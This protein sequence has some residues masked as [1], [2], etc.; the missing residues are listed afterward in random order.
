M[1]L[2]TRAASSRALCGLSLVWVVAWTAPG[3]VALAGD[4]VLQ[5]AGTSKPAAPTPPG[6]K[7]RVADFRALLAHLAEQMRVRKTESSEIVASLDA[8]AAGYPTL[9]PDLVKDKKTGAESEQS[10]ELFKADALDARKDAERLYL[11]ALELAKP[12]AN[13]EE[14]ER[15]AVN[16]KAAQ[17]LATVRP[18][19]REQVIKDLGM[20]LEKILPQNAKLEHYKI[21]PALYEAM[22]RTI[23][24]V[25]DAKNGGIPYLQGWIKFEPSGDAPEKTKA[26]LLG[27]TAVPRDRE[28]LS[29]KVRAEIFL[30]VVRTYVG[31]EN[32]AE[33]FRPGTNPNGTKIVDP[34][35]TWD[36]LKPS[37]IR[38]LQV[39]SLEPKDTDGGLIASVAKFEK[40]QRDHKDVRKE[41][42][43][44][45]Q[46]AG[47]PPPK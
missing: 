39:L 11:K 20:L 14:N 31:P 1:H 12:K 3:G 9:A 13:A 4:G 43:L 30:D 16:V 46:P 7:M 37:V 10:P 26:A 17:V 21:P 2:S 35:V 36:L 5:P 28:H 24:L 42:W 15:D 40:W 8:V 25:S 33:H 23:G 29:G 6:A 47:A 44:D 22:F 34:R 18:E 45:P 27:L 38:A 41:P 19:A 32:T